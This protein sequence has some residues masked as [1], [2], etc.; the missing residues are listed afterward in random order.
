MLALCPAVTNDDGM[1]WTTTSSPVVGATFDVAYEDIPF[2]FNADALFY[3]TTSHSF[4]ADAVIS[5]QT[6]TYLVVGGVH[7]QDTDTVYKWF[8]RSVRS[9]PN[10]I[11]SW[12]TADKL[13]DEVNGSFSFVDIAYGAGRWGAVDWGGATTDNSAAS[14]WTSDDGATWY[15]FGR[16]TDWPFYPDPDLNIDHIAYGNGMWLV[17]GD[18][19]VYSSPGDGNW[20]M[21]RPNPRLG[22]SG[23]RVH[24]SYLLGMALQFVPVGW[25]G[26]HLDRDTSHSHVSGWHHVD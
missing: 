1:A 22:L 13:T 26:G 12:S 15:P 7:K 9:A 10:S 23:Y 4:T 19:G 20:T 18:G 11:D 16:A 5:N 24:H 25:Y 3:S 17:H 8:S 6:T 21:R 2:N 14:I